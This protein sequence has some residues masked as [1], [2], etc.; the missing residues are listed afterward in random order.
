MASLY[1]GVL[2]L[3]RTDASSDTAVIYRH[4]KF[5]DMLSVLRSY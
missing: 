3:Y 5:H 1:K 4:F 2:S